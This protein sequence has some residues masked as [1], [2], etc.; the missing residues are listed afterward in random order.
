MRAI[1][2]LSAQGVHSERSGQEFIETSFTAIVPMN[3]LAH[4]QKPSLPERH[5]ENPDAL[6]S[7]IIRSSDRDTL[8]QALDSVA[9]Q[10]HPLIECLIVN[11]KGPGHRAIPAV[12]GDR[13]VRFID[14]PLPLQRSVAANLGLE[15]AS[16]EWLL[17]LDDDYLAPTHLAGLLEATGQAGAMAVYSHCQVVDGAGRELQHRFAEPFSRAKLLAGNFL[18]IHSV[19]FAGSL[20]DA[21]C[22]FDEALDRFEDWD[23][24]L[25]LAMHTDFIETPM[26]TAFYRVDLGAGFGVSAPAHEIQEYALMLAAKWRERVTPTVFLELMELARQNRYM[27]R[28]RREVAAC[29]L[30]TQDAEDAATRIAQSYQALSTIAEDR[31]RELRECRKN[32]N[33]VTSSTAWRITAPMRRVLTWLRAKACE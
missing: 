26:L 30:V 19:L 20:R 29:G 1:R 28:L 13:Q 11:A 10:T 16:G 25:Q 14:S 17:F 31:T 27:E 15:A 9:E 33:A 32:L 2:G 22:R 23:F 21:G 3:R 5:G 24:W 18:P 8:A 6:I 7:V 12:R 4:G